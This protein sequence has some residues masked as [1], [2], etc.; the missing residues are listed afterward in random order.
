MLVQ[1]P[2][3]YMNVRL[4]DFL[5]EDAP[6]PAAAAVDVDNANLNLRN[7]VV[8]THWPIRSSLT[9]PYNLASALDW[10]AV[11]C[12]ARW[13]VETITRDFARFLRSS[14]R[15]VTAGKIKWEGGA[16]VLQDNLMFALLDDEGGHRELQIWA[17]TPERAETEL[18]RLKSLYLLPEKPRADVDEFFL[19]TC[20]QGDIRA[21]R[22]ETQ[23]LIC[24]EEELG[25]HYGKQFCHWN[26]DFLRKL[27]TRKFG[28]TLLQGA[29]GTGKTSYLRYLLRVLRGT[30]RFYYLPITVYPVLASPASAKFWVSETA[31]HGRR[32]KVV[33]IEDAETLLM[34]RA[35]DNQASLSNLLNIADGFLGAFLQVH[36]I[37]TLNTQIEKLDPALLRPGRLLTRYTFSRLWRDQAKKLAAAKGLKIRDQTDYSLAEIYNSNENDDVPN[38]APIG[39]CK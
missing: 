18:N 16:F 36:I 13:N 21:R 38:V 19:V 3:N 12:S 2:A 1:R 27:N 7:H 20:G 9:N 35:P 6:P 29:P 4:R 32:Q 26:A 22:V 17:D 33:F 28:L 34:E 15:N 24:D 14:N 39:F 5:L 25:L 23:P 37:C 10:H 31:L 8:I 11:T 30:H